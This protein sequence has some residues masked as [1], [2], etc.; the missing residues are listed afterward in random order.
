[1]K[2]KLSSSVNGKFESDNTQRLITI[3]SD[4]ISRAFSVMFIFLNRFRTEP[5][6]SFWGL[7]HIWT[8]CFWRRIW[9][10]FLIIN[11]NISRKRFNNRNINY[12]NN[13][14][15]RS[16]RNVISI[17]KIQFEREGSSIWFQIESFPFFAI[18]LRQKLYLH[19]FRTTTDRP[20]LFPTSKTVIGN[21]CMIH[22]DIC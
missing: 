21:F 14:D 13:N 6:W 3:T 10:L 16:N 18:K 15:N 22:H 19:H 7:C 2:T 5:E 1:M 17:L 20:H 8:D 11:N 4:Y 12:N 9:Y